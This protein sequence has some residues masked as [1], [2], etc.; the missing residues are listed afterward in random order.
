MANYWLRA[1]DAACVN[2]AAEFLRQ[3]VTSLPA[4][5]R[6]GFVRGDAG[7]GAAGVQD[8]AEALGLDFIFAARL[9]Q[10]VQTLC[11]HDEAAWTPTAVAGLAVQEVALERPGR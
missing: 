10:K 1:G 7:F 8:A 2:G 11:R 9:T 4:H 3:T 6:V 5:I